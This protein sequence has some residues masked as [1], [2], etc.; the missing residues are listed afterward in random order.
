MDC[1]VDRDALCSCGI[2]RPVPRRWG[3]T[4]VRTATTGTECRS[5]PPI[6]SDPPPGL[7]MPGCR[8]HRVPTGS[9]ICSTGSIIRIWVPTVVTAIRSPLWMIRPFKHHPSPGCATSGSTCRRPRITRPNMPAS[10]LRGGKA[11]MVGRPRLPTSP[12]SNRQ[13]FTSVGLMR[14]D[15]DQ[16][17][18]RCRLSL[19][20]CR[21]ITTGGTNPT[22]GSA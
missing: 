5:N 21:K 4:V 20:S 9:N 14:D 18:D 11:S 17:H 15:C 3:S 7:R 12:T 19:L 2:R 6:P 16:P 10:S 22:G 13:V 8:R 1:N